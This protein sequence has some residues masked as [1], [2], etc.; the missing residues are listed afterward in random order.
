MNLIERS[1]IILNFFPNRFPS[2]FEWS[3]PFT[4]LLTIFGRVELFLTKH[5][6]P[7]NRTSPIWVTDILNGVNL[8]TRLNSD[9]SCSFFT[10]DHMRP[11]FFLYQYVVCVNIYGL[12]FQ[13]F[14]WQLK[15]F[16][17][18]NYTSNSHEIQILVSDVCA[19]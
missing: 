18:I 5:E 2:E 19:S 4:T 1:K 8:K 6:K 9:I 12:T 7:I 3:D 11:T 15:L 17:P 10:P 16:D 13:I 14:K